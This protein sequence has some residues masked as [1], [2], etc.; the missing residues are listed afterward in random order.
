M[1]IRPFV[2]RDGIREAVC[3]KGVTML[4]IYTL[5]LVRG[6]YY[7]GT[8]T[9]IR[10]RLREHDAGMGSGWTRKYKPI[11]VS[12]KYGVERKETNH[13]DCRMEEDRQVKRVMLEEGIDNVR[14]GTYCEEVMAEGT[15]LVLKRELFH[16]S[17]GCLRCGRKNHWARS[18]YASTDIF[19]EVIDEGVHRKRLRDED[20]EEDTEKD[21]EEDTEEDTNGCETDY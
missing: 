15:R 19:G 20:T 9:N 17:G 14:G 8:T 16:A 6:K 18:C 10:A 7:V 2:Y 11:G 21:T 3:L 4:Y 13:V 1:C 5:Q 12:E